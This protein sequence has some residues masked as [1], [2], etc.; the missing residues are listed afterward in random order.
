MSKLIQQTSSGSFE[1]STGVPVRHGQL[2]LSRR[3]QKQ[4][5]FALRKRD[6]SLRAGILSVLR[7]FS[8]ALCVLLIGLAVT[9]ITP[10]LLDS[11]SQRTL[12]GAAVHSDRTSV[13]TRAVA[14]FATPTTFVYR[15]I[16]GTRH[17]ILSDETGLNRFVNDTL[18]YLES[19]R[20]T[21]KARTERKI[22]ALLDNAFFDSHDSITRYADWYF[23]WGRSW[24]LLKEALVGTIK[25]LAPNSVQGF[26]EAARNGVEAYLIRNYQR[27]VLKPELCNPVI[28]AG[29]ARILAEAHNQYLDTLTAIDERVQI[30]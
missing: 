25:G 18:V 19:Q 29:V 8:K 13:Q 11:M 27:F 16:N 28:E 15:D 3:D 4:P 14:N 22:D 12:H 1:A 2:N 10:G 20:S 7:I 24:Y 17:L 30:F 9:W 21:I 6:Y 26:S 23:E 5:L